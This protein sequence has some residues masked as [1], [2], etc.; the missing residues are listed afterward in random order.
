M[1]N[2]NT[3][4]WC[5]YMPWWDCIFETKYQISKGTIILS[6][7]PGIGLEIKK[8]VLDKFSPPVGG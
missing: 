7:E 1:S 3:Q 5:E 6:E 4:F 8:G 2:E